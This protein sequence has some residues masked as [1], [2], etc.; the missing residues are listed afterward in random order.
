MTSNLV[1]QLNTY[2]SL[3]A[4]DAYHADSLR[5]QAWV[6]YDSD[7]RSQ[8]L[9]TAARL[10]GKLRWSGQKTGV[11][12]VVS[13]VP[14]AA[15][16]GYAVGDLLTALG[17]TAGSP[18]VAKVLTVSGGTVLTVRIVDEG[19]YSVLPTSPAATSGG[20]GTGC[21]LTLTGGTQTMPFPR[22][23]LSDRD[24]NDASSA[25]VPQDIIAGDFEYALELLLDADLE[26]SSGTG[27]NLRAV[28]AGSVSVENFRP[29]DGPDRNQRLPTVVQELVAPYLGGQAFDLTVATGTD[30]EGSFDA[31]DE[32]GL[33]MGIP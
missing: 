33:T 23:G 3:A 12:N 15:G 5:G 24:G 26:T 28:H 11:L 31:D 30:V 6:G 10:F 2:G 18:A 29:T 25:Y 17:G 20:T 14:V 9:L 4:A 1:V 27:T 7:S 19:A 16:T 21:T 13:A 32:Y 22:T 8:A